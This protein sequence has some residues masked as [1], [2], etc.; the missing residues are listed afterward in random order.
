[1]RCQRPPA[2]HYLYSAPMQERLAGI[3]LS[4][5]FLSLLGT[6]LAVVHFVTA[7]LG[8]SSA[9][10]TTPS[11]RAVPAMFVDSI[12]TVAAPAATPTPSAADPAVPLTPESYQAIASR[13]DFERAAGGALDLVQKF[14][15]DFGSA[16]FDREDAI[17]VPTLPTATDDE[18]AQIVAAAPPG[19]IVR[20]VPATYSSRQ[21]RAWSDQLDMQWTAFADA[22]RTQTTPP[23]ANVFTDLASLK[24]EVASV[25][26]QDDVNRVRI[27]LVTLPADSTETVRQTW[28]RAADAGYAPPLDAVIFQSIGQP[29]VQP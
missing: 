1:V 2:V 22:Q 14:G 25:G 23:S 21:L 11:P 7:P 15:S 8:D 20:F 29:Q 18:K 16:W 5:L 19:A 17:V 3:A 26:P 27:G 6:A 24:V 13:V 10:L 12:G 4:A 28:Q 9:G